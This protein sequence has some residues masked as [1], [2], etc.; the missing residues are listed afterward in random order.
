MRGFTC[1][2][3]EAC[4]SRFDLELR[5]LLGVITLAVK[6]PAISHNRLPVGE[7]KL[8]AIKAFLDR[9]SLQIPAPGHG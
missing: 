1:L 3:C 5:R 7:I 4:P 6:S 2:A 8:D 9:I